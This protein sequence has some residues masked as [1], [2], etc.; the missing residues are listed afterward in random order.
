MI[1][2]VRHLLQLKTSNLGG[3]QGPKADKTPEITLRTFSPKQKPEVGAPV[4]SE[5]V[6]TSAALPRLSNLGINSLARNT[7]SL[8]TYIIFQEST[9]MVHYIF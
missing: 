5:S 3:A 1:E 2:Y 6:I 7:S 8:Y 9:V 4:S